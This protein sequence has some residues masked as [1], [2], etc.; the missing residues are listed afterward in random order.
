MNDF[1]IVLLQNLPALIA[2]GVD[3]SG[4][5]TD[6]NARI[7]AAQREKREPSPQDW[8]WLNG[9]IK[10]LQDRLHAPGT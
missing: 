5:I 9:T 4:L 6:A 3:I 1:A 10:E 2:A 8:D 7:A